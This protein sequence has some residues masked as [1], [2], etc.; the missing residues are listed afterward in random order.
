MRGW[1]SRE[2]REDRPRRTRRSRRSRRFNTGITEHTES[3]ARGRRPSAA[4][5]RR[6]DREESTKTSALNSDGVR[7]RTLLSIHP[8]RSAGPTRDAPCARCGPCVETP[9]SP[10]AS[11]LGGPTS[12][13]SWPRRPREWRRSPGPVDRPERS[14]RS[15]TRR[16]ACCWMI[17]SA[18]Q[19]D[20]AD[21]DPTDH[22]KHSARAGR[23]DS[24]LHRRARFGHFAAQ[25]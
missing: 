19:P 1:S 10:V 11:V 23:T 21:D 5:G 9:V 14:A 18:D 25:E 3:V 13:S 15:L 16:C 4:F 12:R 17:A 6:M 22:S 20:Q 2:E 8:A 24:R 7:F